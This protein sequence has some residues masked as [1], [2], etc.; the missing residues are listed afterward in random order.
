MKISNSHKLFAYFA[1]A[2]WLLSSWTGAHKHLCFDG[3]ET[4][5]SYHATLLGDH[6]T[7]HADEQHLDEDVE[8]QQ[9]TLIKIIKW[10]SLIGLIAAFFVLVLWIRSRI[11]P[12]YSITFRATPIYHLRPPSHA[13]PAIPA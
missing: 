8:L 1:L 9:P 3:Q 2:L 10:D 6:L 4:P 12:T 5:V 11:T 13:P 7:H